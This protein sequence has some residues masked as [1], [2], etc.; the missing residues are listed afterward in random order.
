MVNIILIAGHRH[1]ND[2]RLSPVPEH[3][4]IPVPDRLLHRIYRHSGTG[5]PD[6]GPFGILAFE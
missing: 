3:S 5:L 1:L 4:H 2:G 6:A